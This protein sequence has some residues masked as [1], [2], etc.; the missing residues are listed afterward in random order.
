MRDEGLRLAINAAGGIGALARSLG[1]KQPSVSAW[2]KIPADRVLAVES[3]TGVRREQLRPDLYPPS[4]F[5]DETPVH[6][7]TSIDE[8]ERARAGEYFLLARLLRKAPSQQLLDELGRLR[9]DDTPIGMAHIELAEAASRTSEAEVAREFFALFIGLGRGELLP[10]ASYYL[11]GFLHERPLARL[12][13]DLRRLGIERAEDNFDPEDHLGLLLEVMGGFADSSFQ[14][15]VA[16][17][18]KFFERHIEPWAE[19]CFA[20]LAMAESAR[21]YRSVA[22]LG[23]RFIAIEREAFEIGE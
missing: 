11:T 14:A 19:R 20:D 23:A 8:I 21:F 1:I 15:E 12:R 13:E 9:G 16:E 17:Q 6:S 2:V 7:T 18:R 4:S 3:S 10:Y 22:T 5:S